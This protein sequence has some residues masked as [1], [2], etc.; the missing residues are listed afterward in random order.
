MVKRKIIDSYED[1]VAFVLLPFFFS[2]FLSVVCVVSYYTYFI[3][4]LFAVPVICLGCL[5]CQRIN[6][7]LLLLLLLC[8][9]N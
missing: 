1:V 6:N 5:L 9:I 8:V 7:E 3:L 4:R 2:L